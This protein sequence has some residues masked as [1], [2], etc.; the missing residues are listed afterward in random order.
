MHIYLVKDNQI[1]VLG[2]SF[3]S[4]FIHFKISE[5]LHLPL[6]TSRSAYHQDFTFLRS[7]AFFVTKHTKYCLKFLFLILKIEVSRSFYPAWYLKICAVLL[8]YMW[9]RCPSMSVLSGFL[10]M[11]FTSVHIMQ[12]GTLLTFPKLG[13]LFL[14]NISYICTC[15]QYLPG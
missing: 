6:I 3:L 5:I 8:T 2:N 10:Y 12:G 4:S 7:E 13:F 9:K 1:L 15:T 11:C 14:K